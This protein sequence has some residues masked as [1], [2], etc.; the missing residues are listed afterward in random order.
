MKHIVDDLKDKE[1][2]R[3]HKRND[4]TTIYSITKKGKTLT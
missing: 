4:G 3:M 1:L 2:L